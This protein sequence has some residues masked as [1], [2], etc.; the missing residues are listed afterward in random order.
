MIDNI[1]PLMM[2][3]TQF[4]GPFVDGE[5]EDGKSFLLLTERYGGFKGRK[6][7]SSSVFKVNALYVFLTTW[8]SN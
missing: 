3:H 8:M 2:S 7:I 5:R 4:E 1:H 6:L